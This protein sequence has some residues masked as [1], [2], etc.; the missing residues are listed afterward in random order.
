MEKPANILIVF[1]AVVI[2]LAVM[3]AIMHAFMG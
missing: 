2:L 3:T 1:V